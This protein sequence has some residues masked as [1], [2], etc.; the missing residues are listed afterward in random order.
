M[1]TILDSYDQMPYHAGLALVF[2]A[3]DGRQEGFNWLIT[4]CE[5]NFHPDEFPYDPEGKPCWFSGQELTGLVQRND[6]QFIW[7]VISGFPPDIII[8]LERVLNLWH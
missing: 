3:L 2:R 7:A 5:C 8:D 1:N 6:I 4:D